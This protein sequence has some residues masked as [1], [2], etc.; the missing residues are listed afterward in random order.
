MNKEAFSLIALSFII[1]HKAFLEKRVLKK[2][3]LVQ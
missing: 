3:K 2:V 1:I